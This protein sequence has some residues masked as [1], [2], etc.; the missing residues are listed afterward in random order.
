MPNRHHSHA[1]R[2][3]RPRPPQTSSKLP[4]NKFGGLVG[5]IDHITLN[6][7]DGP[8]PDDNHIY[9]W[10]KVP[11]GPLAGKY[12]C[13]FNTQSNQ[14]GAACQFAVFEEEITL[15]DFP[16]F[17]FWD[18]EVSYPGLGLKQSDFQPIQNGQL[19]SAVRDWA[20]DASMIT[21]YGFTYPGGDGIHDIHMNSG[22][23][24]GSGHPNHVNQDGALVMYYRDDRHNPHRRWIFLKFQTQHL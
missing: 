12:E 9:I 16:S 7:H 23:P 22:E 15:G 3:L 10:I 5:E 20:Q 8:K 24:A 14:G 1:N 11:A 18:A 4:G 19:R 17:G 6:P 21:A 2:P 13:A